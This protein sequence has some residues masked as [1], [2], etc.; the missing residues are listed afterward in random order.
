[1]FQ[2]PFSFAGRIRRTEYGLSYVL[3]CV[4]LFIHSAIATILFDVVNYNSQN[5]VIYIGL[6][7]YIPILWFLFAQSAKRCRDLGRSG[8]WQ[9]VPFY[10]FWL[11]FKDGQHSHNRYGEN[12]KEIQYAGNQIFM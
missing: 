4:V 12:P 9:I 3:Y 1:M 7:F 10:G 6:L 2:R 8:W 5:A 11:L